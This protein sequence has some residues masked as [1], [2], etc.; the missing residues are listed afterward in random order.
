VAATA[1]LSF[2]PENGPKNLTGARPLHNLTVS[3]KIF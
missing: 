3:H 1:A 2:H